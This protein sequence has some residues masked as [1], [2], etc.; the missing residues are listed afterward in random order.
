MCFSILDKI[1]F[2]TKLYSNERELKVKSKDLAV[3]GVIKFGSW[4][5]H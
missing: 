4:E 1:F 2:Q 5:K 3:S